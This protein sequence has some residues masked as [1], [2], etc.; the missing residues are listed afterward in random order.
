M[1]APDLIAN[2]QQKAAKLEK[3]KPW[4]Q[5]S[6]TEKGVLLAVEEIYGQMAQ[7]I[8]VLTNRVRKLEGK[9]PV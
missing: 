1:T 3:E 2:A 5:L 9:E 4:I 7:K 8:E 6:A